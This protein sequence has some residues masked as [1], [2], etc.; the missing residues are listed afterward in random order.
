MIDIDDKAFIALYTTDSEEA[1]HVIRR[2]IRGPDTMRALSLCLMLKEQGHIDA[3][4]R[5]LKLL[6]ASHPEEPAISFE[7]GVLL[8]ERDPDAAKAELSRALKIAPDFVSAFR[9]LAL[10]HL[11]NNSIESFFG[12]LDRYEE[13]SNLTLSVVSDLARFYSYLISL[14]SS[15][16]P[17][18]NP[19]INA[20]GFGVTEATVDYS[21]SAVLQ[22]LS[23]A[24]PF[25]LVRYGDGEGA[26]W[27]APMEE[28]RL[29]FPEYRRQRMYFST[30]WFGEDYGKIRNIVDGIGLETAKLLP[31]A[32]VIGAPT[33]AWIKHEGISCN[34][35]TFACCVN[36]AR[37][38]RTAKVPKA[39]TSV[40]FDLL[41]S[42]GL[43]EIIN[44]GRP[45]CLVTSHRAMAPLIE[46]RFPNQREVEQIIIPPA[47]SDLHITKYILS[48]RS[49]CVVDSV[50]HAAKSVD[51]DHIVLVGAGYVGKLVCL[52]L[53]ELG[54]LAIDVG[55][56]FDLILNL[57]TR[58]NFS[59]YNPDKSFGAGVSFLQ[60]KPLAPI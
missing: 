1:E 57:S 18:D 46:H 19:F 39:R 28:E 21:F 30:R 23:N 54:F 27:R 14:P 35:Q 32:D 25:A 40:H 8:F 11:Y 2:V 48:D 4:K 59:M 45:V 55:S 58:P 49:Y 52:K 13:S 33:V 5:N 43:S 36:A 42:G 50:L 56:V 41:D 15:P 34:L 29:N 3:A 53:K 60:P 16:K 12:L 9:C 31:T 47:H 20:L 7:L 37:A 26:L 22:A 10:L 24:E 6:Q 51:R 38:A 44:F 17:S